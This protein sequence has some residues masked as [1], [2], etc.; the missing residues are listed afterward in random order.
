MSKKKTKETSEQPE[1]EGS[2]FTDVCGDMMS[3]NLPDCCA[4]GAEETASAETAC[5]GPEMKGMMA[6]M[7][8]AF[9]RQAD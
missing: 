7:M 2:A 8:G 5:C 3:G 1:A 6:R 4:Q 9:E